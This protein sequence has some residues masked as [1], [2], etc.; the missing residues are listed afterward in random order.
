MNE[1]HSLLNKIK[2]NYILKDILSLAFRN[3]KSVLKFVAYDK[4]L[5][6]KLDINIKEQFDYKIRSTI[7]KDVGLITVPI[8]I[9]FLGYYIYLIIY[10][11]MF[12]IRGKFNDKNL[13]KGYD[14]KKKN[15]IDIM[16]NYI[17]L[18]YLVFLL[19]Y[20]ILSI[21]SIISDKILIKGKK[22]FI[23]YKIIFFINLLYYIS[24]IIKFF[25]TE[26]II[27]KELKEKNEKKSVKLLWFYDFDIAIL[28]F[29][30]IYL[31]LY[32][33]L[34]FVGFDEDKFDDKKLYILNQIN[35]FDIFGFEF[36]SEF[37]NLNDKNKLRIIFKKENMRIY[38]YKLNYS[39][40]KLIDKINELRRQNNIPEL[41]YD[42]WQK[43]PD[44]IINNKTELIFYKEKDIYKFPNNYY[45]IKYPISEFQSEIKDKNI[46]N[47][48]NSDFLDRINIM[49]K[50]N[51]EYIAL[52]NNQFNENNNDENNKNININSR[53][54][55]LSQI[56][57]A[58]TEDKFD[59]H[60]QL[61]NLS[62]NRINENENIIVRDIKVNQNTFEKK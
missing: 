24:Y 11:I 36:N 17:L 14:K 21:L 20:Y 16:D 8:A 61:I 50:D 34:Y 15:Y 58:N 43:L 62:A 41:N 60:E 54:I 42:I 44:Y 53:K 27:N 48:L 13:E 23:I 18:I 7:K 49:R 32:F 30:P 31:L 1:K 9:D 10:D 22:K 29:M 59:E 12:Y 2:S 55:D 38:E 57:I 19:I 33:L 6:Q 26:A 51:Y 25:F 45:L 5:L 56:N 37:E 47:I 35:G 52:Y 4:V 39:Q 40:I 28:G 3:M 46:I